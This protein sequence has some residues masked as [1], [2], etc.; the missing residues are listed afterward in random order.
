MSFLIPWKYKP[1]HA[2]LMAKIIKY[3]I[4]KETIGKHIWEGRSLFKI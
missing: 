1:I 4:M 3:I 2:N